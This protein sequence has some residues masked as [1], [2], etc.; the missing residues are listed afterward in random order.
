MRS[1]WVGLATVGVAFA[2]A[3]CGNSGPSG[4]ATASPS[5]TPGGTAG[6]VPACVTGSWR[7]TSAST[8]AGTAGNGVTGTISGG[9]G[10][11]LTIGGNG[12]AKV[13][14]ASMQPITFAVTAP[15]GSVK[16]EY[17]YR[18][19]AN[20]TLRFPG[21]SGT[22]VPGATSSATGSAGPAT[23]ESA[24]AGATASTGTPE[25]TGTWQPAGD[26]KWEDLRLT[27]KLTEPINQTLLNDARIGS[28]TGN[29]TS[30]A[31]NAVDLQPVLR[32]GTYTCGGG[33]LTVRPQTGP[34]SVTWVFQ[35]G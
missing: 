12:A 29:Q 16:G 31:G 33:T 21:G 24:G 2:V 35:R 13:D 19:T 15:A 30:Q 9:Q 34:A 18:G 28:V 27:L 25:A 1:G 4:T 14:F 8:T 22:A 20:G 3:A 5:A 32:Q 26:V 23:T 10:V 7:S 11:T 6:P 17:S